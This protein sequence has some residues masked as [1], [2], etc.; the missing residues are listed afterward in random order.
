MYPPYV[1]VIALL[2]IEKLFFLLKRFCSPYSTQTEHLPLKV[3]RL[4]SLH[5]LPNLTRTHLERKK[6]PRAG[7]KSFE[8]Y[9]N[10]NRIPTVHAE[11]VMRRIYFQ[12]IVCRL[13]NPLHHRCLSVFISYI[14]SVFTNQIGFFNFSTFQ[15]F[16]LRT[17]LNRHSPG[18]EFILYICIRMN[19]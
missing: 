17:F 11:S 4:P 3:T 13:T 1:N 19:H 12:T 5:D 16:N 15:H 14:H 10:M 7:K 6:K 8:I 9:W 18:G 2:L